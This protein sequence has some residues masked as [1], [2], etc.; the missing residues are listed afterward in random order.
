MLR[1]Y[2]LAAM[3]S[4]D[5]ILG[6][7]VL[8]ASTHFVSISVLLVRRY[9]YRPAAP[10]QRP[11]VTILRPVAGI[12]NYTEETL[13]S[14]FG[15]RYPDFEIVFCVQDPADPVI[16]LIGRLIES[17]PNVPS[18]VLVGD[19]PISDNPKLNN[20]IKGWRAARHEWIAMADSNLL[21]PPTYLDD[22]LSCW[23][24]KVGL[25]SSPPI[26]THPDGIA[27]EL[28]CAFLNTYHARWQ[29][30]ADALGIG[31]AHGKTMLFRRDIVDQA[32]G[33]TALAS[34]TAEDTAATLLVRAA[35]LHVRL[36]RMPFPQPLGRRTLAEMWR[37]QL[38]WAQLRR[39]GVT[40]IFWAEPLSFACLGLT[41]TAFAILS[42]GLSSS[43]IPAL[44]VLWY[45]AEAVLARSYRWP[46][47]IT[48]PVFWIARDLLLPVLWCAAWASRGYEWHGH[49]VDMPL[50]K[51]GNP[52]HL[53]DPVGHDDR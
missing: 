19:D 32:G 31:F 38:R 5:V 24:D 47:S 10:K 8:I 49:R 13:A 6:G 18:R 26:G 29:L 46:L 22:L 36:T 53:K 42:W 44:V 7:L 48:S 35:G 51:N 34:T 16:G 2:G 15:V 14:A 17:H 50:N 3:T 20:L 41:G 52:A 43:L 40:L 11:P 23:S 1:R 21:L 33:I 25:V 12:E 39:G 27:G 45:G 4:Y 28:E 30:A 9:T 37:R